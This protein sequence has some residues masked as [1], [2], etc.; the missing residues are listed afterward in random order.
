MW[1]DEKNCGADTTLPKH[2]QV[3]KSPGR[4]LTYNTQNVISFPNYCQKHT[5]YTGDLSQ[6]KTAILVKT[7]AIPIPPYL[8]HLQCMALHTYG[9]ESKMF[10]SI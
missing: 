8:I 4:I 10:F 7:G 6:T 5:I 2:F 3:A 1:A 9:F